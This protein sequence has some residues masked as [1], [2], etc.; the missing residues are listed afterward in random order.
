MQVMLGIGGVG[1]ADSAKLGRVTAEGP[2]WAATSLCYALKVNIR[3]ALLAG[4]LL[5]ALAFP[6]ADGLQ[7]W[8]SE[9]LPIN[10][11]PA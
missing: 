4:R 6:K 8:V 7:G 5:K 11:L 10:I 2:C 1:P 3:F 9:A